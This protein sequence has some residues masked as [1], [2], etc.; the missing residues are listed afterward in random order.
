MNI[1]R[2]VFR[3]FVSIIAMMIMILTTMMPSWAFGT[4]EIQLEQQSI[5]QTEQ[6]KVGQEEDTVVPTA[7]AVS[8][9][10][11]Y[12]AS[13]EDDSIEDEAIDNTDESTK[14]E[15]VVVPTAEAVSE[16]VFYEASTEDDSI[17]DEAI[18]N[19]DESTKSEEAVKVENSKVKS[20]SPVV[21]SGAATIAETEIPVEGK[22]IDI[23]DNTIGSLSKYYYGK[24]TGIEISGADVVS[25]TEDE[26]IVNVVL[27]GSTAADTD[28]T[29][30]FK[31]EL[32]RFTITPETVSV[33]LEN[34]EGKI[35]TKL[36][37]KY[38]GRIE[39]GNATYTINFVC[40]EIITGPPECLVNQDTEET[41]PNT[42]V[43]LNLKSYFKN[44]K[45]YYIVED[46]NLKE[47]EGKTY[48]FTSKDHGVYELKFAAGN[49][50]GQCSE[51]CTVTITVKELDGAYIG[52][53]TS[54]GS[55]NHVLIT[56]VDGKPINGM[57]ANF[58]SSSKTIDV[59]L[60][61]NYDVKGKVKATFNLTQNS[62]GLPFVSP[63]NGASG[64]TSGKAWDQ[65]TNTYVT[66]LS[67][68]EGR[69]TVYFY[70]NKPTAIN[71][72]YTTYT[73]KYK[74]KNEIPEI[75]GEKSMNA[76]IYAGEEFTLDL[77]GIFTDKDGDELTYKVSVNG[78]DPMDAEQVYSYTNDLGD[79]YT[80]V[81]TATDGKDVSE[82]YTVNLVV[83]NAKKSY[84]VD[85]RVPSDVEP[86]F[87]ITKGKD[88]NNHDIAGDELTAISGEE[89]DGFITYTVAVPE[90]IKQVSFR[91]T[92][93]GGSTDWG[94]MSVETSRGMKEI[95]LRQMMGV[96]TTKIGG[97]APAAEQAVFQ[98][99]VADDYYAVSGGNAVDEDGYLYYRFFMLAADNDSIY[100]YYT[101]A[102]GSLANTY[103][104][105]Q[106]NYKT[107]SSDSAEI[108]IA[109]M[110]LKLKKALTIIT[111]EG[112]KARLFGQ[113]KYYNVTEYQP[114]SVVSNGDGTKSWI[115]SSTGN[116]LSYRVSMDGEITKAGYLTGKE[117]T[118]TVDWESDNRGPGYSNLYDINTEY[119]QRSDDSILMNVNGQNNLKLNVGQTFKLKSYR[120]WQIINSDT[121]NIMIEPDFNYKV[122]SGQD[123]ISVTPFESGTGN[124][125]NNWANITAKK[126]GIA[127]L[128]VSYDAIEVTGAYEETA[129]YNACE[130]SRKGTVV[131]QVGSAASDVSFGIQSSS[132]NSGKA[133]AWDAEFDTLYFIGDGGQISLKPSVVS[134]SIKEV[135]VS[136]NQGA[137]W[138]V[139]TSE[140]GVYTAPVVSGGNILRITKGDGTVA[141]QIVNGDKISISLSDEDGDKLI[142]AG[143]DVTIKLNG[144][145]NPI[146]KMSGVYNPGY[147]YGLYTVYDFNG[148]TV[149]GQAGQYRYPAQASITVTIPSDASEDQIF[150][151]INGCI[152]FN[153]Y[154]QDPGYH[155][156]IADGG[157]TS[158]FAESH[159]HIRSIL[160]DISLVVG[161][162]IE[163]VIV[164]V[165]SI[166][167]DRD[168]AEVEV[169]KAVNL[170]ASVTPL[171][172]TEKD[173][174]WSSSD[175]TVASV[176]D[177]T[178]RAVA[179]GTAEITATAGGKTAV[180][181]VTVVEAAD[182]GDKELVFDIAEEEIKGYITISFVDNG[183]R[184]GD[185]EMDAQFE[186]PLGTIIEPVAVPFKKYENIAEVTLR[187]L[188]AMGITYEYTGNINS[189]FYLSSI[190]NF[191]VDKVYYERFGEFDAGAG[192]GWMVTQND[193]FIN[194]GASEFVANDG[195]IIEWQ[196]TCQVGSDIGDTRSEELIADVEKLINEIK[197]PITEE[198]RAS[199]E[200]ARKAYNELDDFQKRMVGNYESLLIA[201]GALAVLD[202]TDE[203][204][205]AADAVK[206]MINSIGEVTIEKADF[207]AAARAEYN[208]L[209]ELQKL[210]VDNY[211]KLTAAEMKLA[212]LKSAATGDVYKKTGDYLEN[213]GTPTVNSIGGEWMVIGL[214]R[215][216]RDVADGYYDNVVDY[217]DKKINDKGQLHR[218]KSTDN[219]RVILALTSI[220][221]DV[222]D[223]NG[224][225]L[226]EGLADLDYLKKQGINGP[227]WALIALDSHK[228]EIP[229]VEVSG[230]KATRENIVETILNAQ[231]TDGGWALSG[232]NADADMTAMAIQALA[233]YYKTN[234]DVKAAIDSAV[235]TLSELQ[236]PDGSYY[237]SDGY[238][239]A[240]SCAQ[241]VAALT[242]IGIDPSSDDRFVKNGV[243]AIDVLITFA[244][245]DGGFA[246][247]AG[248]KVDGMATE[249]GYYALAAYYRMLD[250]KTSL[251]DMTDVTIGNSTDDGTSE[252]GTTG[253]ADN[254]ED[255][256]EDKN[257]QS[258]NK[259][260][261]NDGMS[262]GGATGDADNNEGKNED[263]NQQSGNKTTT[264]TITKSANVKL[265]NTTVTEEQLAQG[266]EN[267]YCE[268]TGV[269]AR[270]N[271]NDILPWYIKL[272]VVKQ[273]ITDDQKAKVSEVLGGE[274]EVFILMDI[275]F[276]NTKDDSEWQPTK[277]VK[278]KLP[279][280]DIGDYENA[281]IV[282]ITDDGKIEL[283]KGTVKD[284][285]IEF[286]ADSFSLYGIAGTNT[287]INDLLVV[288][289][290][291]AV[292][293]PWIIIAIIALAAIAY[294]VYRRKREV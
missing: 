288:E 294:L 89:A 114:V 176:E 69:A 49:D 133:A 251:Y 243:S 34:G 270:D 63:K 126:E 38:N 210:L 122:V 61:G 234:N 140:D 1:N 182:T 112:A 145:H 72:N 3:K 68:G 258:G 35:Q 231:L 78:G 111:P 99:A 70:D 204:K 102:L 192:S 57:Q 21:R 75:V 115:F 249:Q 121:G 152:D 139:L 28:I 203:D 237:S 130:P 156:T 83:K 18:D 206:E 172:A 281:I 287:S 92:T 202:A 252:G 286:E 96:I 24:V 228:Y 158:A 239:N 23:T 143:E 55:L 136:N 200:K 232:K 128:E 187:L 181:V 101:K 253:D 110:P 278:I 81:F 82:I 236:K 238:A 153:I 285:M 264:K 51:Y 255:K 109:P 209:T 196:Y 86:A 123:V 12:E 26:T 54:N 166:S 85:F 79:N 226:L 279:M 217:V 118:L 241:V 276:T 90:N 197:T 254:N 77:G 27:S 135:A 240:E 183:V 272:N 248:G 39:Y 43:A 129:V 150:E 41:Y 7:E 30:E 245:E 265:A 13:T 247:E 22:L 106:G 273:E 261:T 73:I 10:V 256:N 230:T 9:E 105:N 169:G 134:G 98:A 205:G 71:N 84:G 171:N 227:I 88:S 201:E 104:T 215:S 52:A 246:H 5:V 170:S 185:E 233:P 56:D 188:D 174:V 250:G 269:D 154:G 45:T 275:H 36:T 107:V 138:T 144:V 184:V 142:E 76:E 160:P 137:D 100:T 47:L 132:K 235:K 199:V 149:K 195:D 224:H 225:N 214:A 119:G 219:S 207:I 20:I 221:K 4:E 37:A 2:K 274:G 32:N 8:E 165:Q 189:N 282:H 161:S 159:Y 40:A 31:T 44:A 103:G 64:T 11:F 220:G 16:E 213:L 148:A 58:D 267:H 60:P 257:Q 146:G 223:V 80:L 117:E 53:P 6:E 15:E 50:Y 46:D 167:I 164:P 97:K 116:Y 190:G 14:S 162:E 67:N 290:D 211:D 125:V 266:K 180:C 277:P 65:R 259:T 212:V 25:A 33:T 208:K 186:E 19:T 242:A 155:R 127:V 229:D 124:A 175:N 260:T 91:G 293:W 179:V 131:V 291:G 42:A 93:D 151:L 292:I 59:V 216:D 141:Y 48:N 120:S 17:E 62:S 283:I 194:K 222:T 178:V 280:V 66:T 157:M 87:Y 262:E 268:E 113:N 147:G 284:G 94:G 198:S 218:S 168:K 289:D 108:E 271:S 244:A 163:D 74:L 263:K 29:V 193:W 95:T 173:I 177:G 191:T